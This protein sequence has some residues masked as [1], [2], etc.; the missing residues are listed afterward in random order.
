[1]HPACISWFS[2]QLLQS[3]LRICPW[4]PRGWWFEP[5]TLIG[6]IIC[7]WL[8]MVVSFRNR[9]FQ[10]LTSWRS[11]RL[12]SLFVIVKSQFLMATWLHPNVWCWNPAAQNPQNCWIL[13]VKSELWVKSTWILHGTHFPQSCEETWGIP[14]SEAYIQQHP[15]FFMVNPC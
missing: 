4:H 14:I 5:P 10:H 3:V 13:L 11:L 1:M 7:W 2:Q 15:R 8:M 12:E 6:F 9:F